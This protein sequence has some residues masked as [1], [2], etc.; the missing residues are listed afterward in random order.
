MEEGTGLQYNQSKQGKYRHATPLQPEKG[1]LEKLR[2]EL[3]LP[4][5]V[6]QGDNINL[7]A[8]ELTWALQTAMRKAILVMKEVM[9]CVGNRQWNELLQKLCEYM[10]GE[11]YKNTKDA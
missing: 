10:Q 9:R 3:V 11:Q 7:N 1:R 8:K 5:P 6:L 2:R 4:Q